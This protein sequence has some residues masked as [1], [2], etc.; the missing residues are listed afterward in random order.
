[1]MRG[2]TEPLRAIAEPVDGLRTAQA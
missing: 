2:L 1:V